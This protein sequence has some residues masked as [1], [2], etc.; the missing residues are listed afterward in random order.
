MVAGIYT[1]WVI[2]TAVALSTPGPLGWRARLLLQ[3]GGSSLLVTLGLA[4]AT[5]RR[6]Q[7]RQIGWT[8]VGIGVLG[9]LLWTWSVITP[10]QVAVLHPSGHSMFRILGGASRPS[11]LVVSTTLPI[12]DGPIDDARREQLVEAA[13]RQYETELFRFAVCY[14]QRFG[15][16]VMMAENAVQ[17]TFAALWTGD[18]DTVWQR[19]A[20]G[21]RAY[22]FTSIKLRLNTVLRG[23][24]RRASHEGAAAVEAAS[25][26]ALA[27]S[28][29]AQHDESELVERIRLGLAHCSERETEAFT[30]V[31]LNDLSYAE[32]A[33]IMGISWKTISTLLTRATQRI[34]PFVEDFLSAETARRPSLP[35]VRKARDTGEA[36]A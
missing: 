5:R 32:A 14:G 18:D 9:Q 26:C 34:Q 36:T 15:A 22:L 4:L 19:D 23:E 28:P 16:D 27:A 7:L 11:T 10:H 3:E 8:L 20:S 2:W 24:D 35:P 13:Y 1:T 29:S 31:R 25:G 21:L 6:A 33:E 17:E 12:G 30:L